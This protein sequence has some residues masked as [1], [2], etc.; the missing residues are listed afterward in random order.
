M[1]YD[2][3]RP[4]TA[5]EVQY[6]P[7]HNG[8]CL[9]VARSLRGV[10]KR[11]IITL[12]YRRTSPS[13]VCSIGPA[14]TPAYPIASFF[15]IMC[16]R[17]TPAPP[18]APRP[19]LGDLLTETA[20]LL[21]RLL[22][23]LDRSGVFAAAA[24]AATAATPNR[25]ARNATTSAADLLKQQQDLEARRVRMASRGGE[26]VGVGELGRMGGGGAGAGWQHIARAG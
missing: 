4:V 22:D 7:K 26:G 17:S 11:S 14:L 13:R 20:E 12:W 5:P 10:W 2:I 8:A 1:S 25:S 18:M 19:T 24:G 3:G 23:F 16:T 21:R 6:S 9:A 15:L